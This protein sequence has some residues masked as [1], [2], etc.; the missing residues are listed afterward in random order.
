MNIEVFKDAGTIDSPKAYQQDKIRT[1][2]MVKTVIDVV[3]LMLYVVEWNRTCR[4]DHP[5]KRPVTATIDRQY[6]IRYKMFLPCIGL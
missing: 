6:V 3:T 1:A 2:G 5:N 4:L